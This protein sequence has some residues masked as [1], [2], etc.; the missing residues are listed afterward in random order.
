MAKMK[1][2]YFSVCEPKFMKVWDT[3]RPFVVSNASQF[4]Y[5]AFVSG[6]IGH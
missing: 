6:A 3:M 2:L 5:I 4:I 1:I